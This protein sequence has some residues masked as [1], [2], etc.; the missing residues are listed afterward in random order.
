MKTSFELHDVL[1]ANYPMSEYLQES[2][3]GNSFEVVQRYWYVIT[4]IDYINN[5]VTLHSYYLTVDLFIFC[6]KYELTKPIGELIDHIQIG[7]L[8]YS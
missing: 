4:G 7:R 8:L 3:D 6:H 2:S 1:L 5:I